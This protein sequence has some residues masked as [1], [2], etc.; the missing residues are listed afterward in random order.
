M[1]QNP[2][3]PQFKTLIHLLDLT[4]SGLWALIVVDLLPFLGAIPFVQSVDTWIKLAMSFSGVVYFAV[5]IR[6][7]V[8]ETKIKSEELRKLKKQNDENPS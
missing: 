5:R 6:H 8:V 3:M 1:D 2:K 7:Q 4:F